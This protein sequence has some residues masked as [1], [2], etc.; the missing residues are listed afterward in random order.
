MHAMLVKDPY[1]T[2][3]CYSLVFWHL[4]LHVTWALFVPSKGRCKELP[5]FPQSWGIQLQLKV[6]AM[7]LIAAH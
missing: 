7:S 6:F 5:L 1:L 3:K 4:F 2:S